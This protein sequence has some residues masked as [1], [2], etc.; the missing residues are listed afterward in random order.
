MASWVRSN[1]VL[2]AGTGYFTFSPGTSIEQVCL[3]W[4]GWLTTS[5][6]T[7]SCSHHLLPCPL[8]FTT[9]IA[10]G[11]ASSRHAQIAHDRPATWACLLLISQRWGRTKPPRLTSSLQSRPRPRGSGATSSLLALLAIAGLLVP[12][13]L[14]IPS[15]SPSLHP[16]K[17]SLNRLITA[18][19]HRFVYR[20]P[21]AT[22]P[23]ARL[24]PGLSSIARLSHC[25]FRPSAPGA[26]SC[27]LQCLCL[28]FDT[29]P[30]NRQHSSIKRPRQ[31]RKRKE[32]K[33]D[34]VLN[35]QLLDNGL[36]LRVP[37]RRSARYSPTS[38]PGTV[39]RYLDLRRP[40]PNLC[41]PRTPLYRPLSVS[42]KTFARPR[43]LQQ[44]S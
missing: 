29:R 14:S 28:N 2:L 40:V 24:P 42:R 44:S 21:G 26:L 30:T 41:K 27:L 19:D 38:T 22:L 25:F 15:I 20:D 6:T 33:K 7:F 4:L 43:C 12:R 37:I 35:W 32:K 5:G 23:P 10:K 31:D 8:E 36:L 16:D 13:S 34:F 11:P 9:C 3:L 39:D 1:Y 17:S 18:L